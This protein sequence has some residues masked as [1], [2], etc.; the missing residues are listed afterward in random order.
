MPPLPPV[1]NGCFANPMFKLLAAYAW[2]AAP[3]GSQRAKGR[4]FLRHVGE[5]VNQIAAEVTQDTAT[6][7]D[8]DTD[9]V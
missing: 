4:R 3:G 7:K 5:T 9:L 2:R 1:S 8:Y 6:S